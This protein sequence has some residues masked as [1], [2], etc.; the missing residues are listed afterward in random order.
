MLSMKKNHELFWILEVLLLTPTALFWLG[1]IS[2]AL[3]DSNTLFLAVLGA[4]Y[5]LLK[6]FFVAILCP[7]AAAWIAYDYIRENKKDRK[8]TIGI[9]KAILWVSLATIGLVL[10]YI[11]QK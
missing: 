2:L 9:A 5:S 4:P 8:A 11:F 7:A 3:T 1:I 10:I 6:G